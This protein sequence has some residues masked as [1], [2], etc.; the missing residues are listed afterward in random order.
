MAMK[1][2]RLNEFDLVGAESFAQA[3]NWYLAFTGMQETEAIDPTYAPYE[4]NPNHCFW[5]PLSDLT[6]K[7]R[8]ETMEMRNF[9]GELYTMISYKRALE[10]NGS[11]EPFIV[12][13][14][15]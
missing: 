8:M 15:S 3:K 1:V 12:A 14:S 13:S 4:I 5:Y 9:D 10:L 2:F 11:S 6:E 7:E